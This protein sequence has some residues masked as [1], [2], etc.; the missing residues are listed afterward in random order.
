MSSFKKWKV[1]AGKGAKQELCSVKWRGVCE[2]D[3][4]KKRLVA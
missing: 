3:E 4:V 1:T 2:I